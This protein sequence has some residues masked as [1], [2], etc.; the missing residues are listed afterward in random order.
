VEASRQFYIAAD[1]VAL[2]LLKH[3]FCIFLSV[4]EVLELSKNQPLGDRKNHRC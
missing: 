1:K 3:Y 2:A 4:P